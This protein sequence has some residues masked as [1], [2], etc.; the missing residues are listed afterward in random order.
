MS[1]V[2]KLVPW[3]KPQPD[4]LQPVAHRLAP[5]DIELQRQ[6][7]WLASELAKVNRERDWLV[8]EV[9]RLRKELTAL[10]DRIANER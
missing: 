8:R 10:Q 4:A 1:W 7:K 6:N 3:V 9:E 2:R 5:C